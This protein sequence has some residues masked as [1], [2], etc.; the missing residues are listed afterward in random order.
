MVLPVPRRPGR[1]ADLLLPAEGIGDVLLGD[2]RLD[3]IHAQGPFVVDVL[4]EGVEGFVGD[5]RLEETEVLQVLGLDRGILSDDVVLQPPIDSSG[6]DLE[7]GGEQVDDLLAPTAVVVLGQCL[8]QSGLLHLRVFIACRP[9]LG[10][11]R[12]VPPGDLLAELVERVQIRSEIGGMDGFGR[13][14]ERVIRRFQ[15]TSQPLGH[16]S[17]TVVRLVAEVLGE[18]VLGFLPEEL[19]VGLAVEELGIGVRDERERAE[20][21]PGG[22]IVVLGPLVIDGLGQVADRFVDHRVPQGVAER[23]L[24]HD[25]L[26]RDGDD[27]SLAPA[28]SGPG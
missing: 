13:L 15:L 8:L 25:R 24:G 27:R 19:D 1:I 11:P 7:G 23:A 17:A 14:L 5:L 16:P 2:D 21:R 9:H 3:R 28:A 10:D 26:R 4:P 20:S 12:E 22:P 6:L 18:L